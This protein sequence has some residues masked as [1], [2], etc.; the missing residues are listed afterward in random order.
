MRFWG[1]LVFIV[2]IGTLLAQQAGFQRTPIEG[3]RQNT[4]GVH[5]LVNARVVV[6]PGQVLENATIVVRNGIIE[7]V[8]KGVT[9]P[10]DARIW[11]Y[12]GKPFTRGL[13]NRS[14]R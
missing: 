6:G 10:A 13:L 5:A 2:S 8:G 1:L 11:D 4:P 12:S 7:A 9:P 14:G 3:I